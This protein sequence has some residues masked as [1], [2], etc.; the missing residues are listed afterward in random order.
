MININDITYRIG[1]RILFDH[2]TAV[3]RTG[4]KVGLIGRN[5]SGK[6]TLF[7]ILLGQLTLDGG[8]ISIQKGLRIGTVT[9]ETPSGK[10]SL[11]NYVLNADVEMTDLLARAETTKDAY[12]IA[13]VHTRLADINAQSA[14][15]RAARILA[16]LGF[17]EESQQKNLDD[18]SGGWRMRVALAAT[19]FS[20][21]DI[22]LLDEPTNH[23]DLEASLWLEAYLAS[24]SG[25][26][27]VISHDRTL[28]NQSV[29]EIWY[30]NNLKLTRYAGGYDDF[31]RVRRD[32]QMLNNKLRNKQ[33]AERQ[34]IE[35]FINRFRYKATKARQ[36]QSRIKM[37]ERMEP[38]AAA[39]EDQSINF[40]FPKP[41]LLPP[42][43]IVLDELDAG[44]DEKVILKKLKLRIDMEDRIGLLGANG[45]GKSTLL[46]IISSRLDPL[47]GNIHKSSKLRVG[48]F[49][50]HQTDELNLNETAFM[51]AARLM[52]KI[53]ESKIR[54]H[55]GRFGFSGNKANTECTNLSGGEKAKLLFALMSVS[56]PHVLLLD[57]PTNHLDI[58]ARE[59][60]IHA[61]NIFDGAVIIVSHDVHLLELVCDSLW[62]I[63]DGACASFS[64]DL[65]DYRL[66]LIDTRRQKRSHA[67]K[68]SNGVSEKKENR[69]EERRRQAAER[70]ETRNLRKSIH[71]LELLME[72]LLSHREKL[73]AKLADPE[74]YEGPTASLMKI[75]IELGDVK[76]R[77]G[78]IENDWM[79]AN[80]KLEIVK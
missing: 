36:A 9:Q 37:L 54:A 62:L 16:G 57:E 27:L 75:Q 69:K 47:F 61:L 4:H 70:A 43:L 23:L 28:L 50:Q 72:H 78:K 34:R 17:N 77:L 20:R 12:E 52:P 22:L 3:V 79:K 1:G 41:D 32:Q 40:D 18:F 5:G 68:L 2:S 11:I 51:H 8:E 26:L 53:E 44:Y 63:E 46:K 67:R 30:L 14:P 73:E 7:K 58:D 60:L 74:V 64:G 76:S 31:E 49:S 21:P 35:M 56:N 42:P 39:A 80:E 19:L 48:Y 13:D 59:A 65:E 38:I 15:S 33:L 55:L 6:S 45:N 24:W 66:H 29:S 71:D 10:V 25:T